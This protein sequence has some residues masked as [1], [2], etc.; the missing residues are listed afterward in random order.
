MLRLGQPIEVRNASRGG[1]AAATGAGG[2]VRGKFRLDT[3]QKFDWTQLSVMLMLAD[4][5]GAEF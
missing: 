2:Q 1:I 4:G 3:E 5:G